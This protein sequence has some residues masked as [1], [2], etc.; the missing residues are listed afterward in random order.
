MGKKRKRLSNFFSLAAI[1]PTDLMAI[2]NAFFL[3]FLFRDEQV[4][5]GR[6]TPQKKKHKTGMQVDRQYQR[7]GYVTAQPRPI[8]KA[9]RSSAREF[10]FRKSCD[11]NERRRKKKGCFSC[12]R[13]VVKMTLEKEKERADEIPLPRLPLSKNVLSQSATDLSVSFGSFTFMSG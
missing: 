5:V 11:E 12:R 13:A 8:I 3:F 2:V 1:A 9:C 7:R 6:T 4:A 10:G